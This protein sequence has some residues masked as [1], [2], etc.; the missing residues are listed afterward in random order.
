M[1]A[2][3]LGQQGKVLLHAMINTDGAV[4][5]LDIHKTSVFS[6]LDQAALETVRN[7]RFVPARRGDQT[8]SA[9]VIVPISFTL[10]G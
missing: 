4:T 2:R 8:V 7:W 1:I 10:E 5:Q 9:W 3:R 6:R